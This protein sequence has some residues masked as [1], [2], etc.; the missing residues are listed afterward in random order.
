MSFSTAPATQDVSSSD[1]TFA[2]ATF[3]DAVIEAHAATRGVLNTT[4]ALRHVGSRRVRVA[5]ECIG[6]ADAP[7]LPVPAS[8]EAVDRATE[9]RA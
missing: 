8:S 9:T 4:F 5:W 6:P 7:L 2:A 3:S 1:C